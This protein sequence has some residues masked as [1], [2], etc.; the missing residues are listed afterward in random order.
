MFR[1]AHKRLY[2][3]VFAAVAGLGVLIARR[4]VSPDVSFPHNEA[5]EVEVEGLARMQANPQSGVAPSPADVATGVEGP[6][7]ATN[8]RAPAETN[9]RVSRP[10][11]AESLRAAARAKASLTAAEDRAVDK[12]GRAAA[13]SSYG[14]IL[15]YVHQRTGGEMASITASAIFLNIVSFFAV[16]V[17]EELEKRSVSGAADGCL[18]R[19]R[20]IM[21][22]L[23]YEREGKDRDRN[24]SLEVRQAKALE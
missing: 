24:E 18:R 16:K 7:T 5:V 4:P 13:D 17:I 20:Q 6:F 23:G 19:L 14:Q 21:D 11:D 1:G 8:L 9:S 10:S 22:A 3:V 15:D 12:Q 2:E